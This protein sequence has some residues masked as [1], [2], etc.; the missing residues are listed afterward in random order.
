TSEILKAMEMT[1]AIQSVDRMFLEGAKKALTAV[2]YSAL[3]FLAANPGASEIELAKRL[4][5]GASAIGLTMA[6]Y[7]EAAKSGLLRETAKD[8][9]IRRIW[10]EY[11]D[12]WFTGDEIGACVRLG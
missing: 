9:L 1:P 12:G 5:G 2:G 7:E 3:G 11:P 8:L 4:K 6:I 10:D